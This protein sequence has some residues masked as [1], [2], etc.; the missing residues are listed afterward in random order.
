MCTGVRQARVARKFRGHLRSCFRVRLA[1]KYRSLSYP[2]KGQHAAN[3]P[4]ERPKIENMDFSNS[5]SVWGVPPH[6]VHDLRMLTRHRTQLIHQRTSAKNQLH[7]LLHR[8]NLKLPG[9][10]PFS[11]ATE[12]WWQ[13]LSLSSVERL[14]LRHSW[15]TIHHLNGLI[16]ETEANIAQLSVTVP[17]DDLMP[18]L[19]QCLG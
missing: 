12:S 4:N 7:A 8:H 17:W 13:T 10:E 5:L 15:S 3:C 18:F 6:H 9:G 1:F 14:Q 2:N 11:A 16:A 19:I